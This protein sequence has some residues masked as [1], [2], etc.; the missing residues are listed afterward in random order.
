MPMLGDDDEYLSCLSANNDQLEFP[1]HLT[2]ELANVAI[3]YAKVTTNLMNIRT[4]S[5]RA[6]GC[7][8]RSM[9]GI[10]TDI[11]G[12]ATNDQFIEVCCDIVSTIKLNVESGRAMKVR[13]NACYAASNCLKPLV[14]FR[15]KRLER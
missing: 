12:M 9:D 1:P 2:V 15:N 13:W 10:Y 7:F 4:S 6:L 3:K 14:L 8:M 5:V 11:P